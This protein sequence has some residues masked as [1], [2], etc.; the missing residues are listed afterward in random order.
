[1][2]VG[3]DQDGVVR[4]LC[5]PRPLEMESSKTPDVVVEQKALLWI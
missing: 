5:S 4:V 1:M 2:L 3:P